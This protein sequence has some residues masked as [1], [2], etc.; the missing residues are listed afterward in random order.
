M[1]PQLHR[2]SQRLAGLGALVSVATDEAHVAITFAD[3]PDPA[4]TGAY[5]DVLSRTNARA[6]FFVLAERA[7]RYPDM[8]ER[9]RAEGHEL[10]VH[11]WDHRNLATSGPRLPR[12]AFRYRRDLA[13]RAREAIDPQARW[14]RPTFDGHNPAV[15]RAIRAA[16]MVPV[17]WSVSAK[18]WQ[19]RPATQI[20]HTVLD[21]ITAG[22]IVLWHDA[23]AETR[24]PAA[25]D[26]SQSLAAL[27]CVLAAVSGRLRA[28]TLSE[29][30]D[31]GRPVWRMGAATTRSGAA[32]ALI[33]AP[34]DEP[35][36]Y[37]GLPL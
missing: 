35:A 22:D 5:L 33:P 1:A 23:I 2:M 14:Y 21:R 7:L 26:R 13:V 32:E 19:P 20:V 37:P 9:I 34:T 17:S 3:G 25:F 24:T 15:A 8:M 36:S 6:T 31:S 27:D 11:G 18:D 10:A 29:L 4:S 28:I 12:A 16:G 30:V